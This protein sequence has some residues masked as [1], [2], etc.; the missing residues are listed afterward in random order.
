MNTL[1]TW[2]TMDGGDWTLRVRVTYDATFVPNDWEGNYLVE[3]AHWI[4]KIEKVESLDPGEGPLPPFEGLSRE[5]RE[6]LETACLVQQE[7]AV[8]DC[9][10][11][12]EQD[13]SQ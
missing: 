8:A 13:L 1:E 5:Q 2:L 6:E 10:E 7:S 9:E 12:E 11:C 3:A 4:V